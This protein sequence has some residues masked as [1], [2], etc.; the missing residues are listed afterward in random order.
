MVVSLPDQTHSWASIS[1]WHG[2][3]TR[4]SNYCFRTHRKQFCPT[5]RFPSA[6][7]F[8]TSLPL[9]FFF[10]KKFLPKLAQD[11]K[12]SVLTTLP[13]RFSWKLENFSFDIQ[14]SFCLFLEDNCKIFSSSTSFSS[15]KHF[16]GHTINSFDN[17]NGKQSPGTK[18]WLLCQLILHRSFLFALRD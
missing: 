6:R 15:M 10:Q 9:K 4:F 8:W 3:D 2:E 5:C 13:K 17:P 7:I 1:P 18:I 16:S 11:L 12:I 14:T